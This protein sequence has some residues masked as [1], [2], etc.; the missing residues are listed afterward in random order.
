MQK[1][2][3]SII[4]PVVRPELVPRCIDAIRKSGSGLDYEIITELDR[5]FIGCPLMVKKMVKEC[6]GEYVLFLG[7]DTIP[8]PN[9]LDEAWSK[10][11]TFDD[12]IGLVALND[13]TGRKLLATHWLASKKLLPLIGGEFF[14][15]G[16]HHTYCDNELSLRTQLLNKY[17]YAEKSVIEHDNPIL[18]H[19][20]PLDEHYK[21]AYSQQDNDKR[22]F[23]DRKKEIIN[24]YNK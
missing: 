24:A 15:T 1:R 7:D 5:D 19:D 3:I 10:M 20:R 4:I 13:G 14:H 18:K 23:E 17:V 9:F 6:K 21:R 16:Y 11:G 12:G 2:L 22:L 8:Q